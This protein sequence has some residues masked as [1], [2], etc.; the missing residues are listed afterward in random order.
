MT[1]ELARRDL[2][3]VCKAA[4]RGYRLQVVC[5]GSDEPLAEK[6]LPDWPDWPVFPPEAAHA[7]GSELL[8]LGYMIRPDTVTADSLIGWH[9]LPDQRAWVAAVG[10]FDQLRASGV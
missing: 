6:E 8:L 10:S 1:N 9:S 7:A 4:D 5:D 2:T 3:A